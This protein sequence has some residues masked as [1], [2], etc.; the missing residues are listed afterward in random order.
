[1]EACLLT[2]ATPDEIS[3]KVMPELMPMD[4]NFYK[5]CFFDITEYPAPAI[6]VNI[7]NSSEPDD[8]EN[9]LWKK[10]AYKQPLDVFIKFCLSIDPFSEEDFQMIKNIVLTD[11]ARN[12]LHHT[13][14]KKSRQY[15]KELERSITD[16]TTEHFTTH[17]SAPTETQKTMEE[18]RFAIASTMRPQTKMPPEGAIEDVGAK[19]YQQKLQVVKK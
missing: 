16:L 15:S 18:F 13:A 2:S 6:F 9:H 11:R 14:D 19:E 8:I 7:I 1:M 12:M 10:L 4:I 3:K 17:T 5:N